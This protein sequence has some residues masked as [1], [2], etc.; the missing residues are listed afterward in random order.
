MGS[1]REFRTVSG[2]EGVGAPPG[3]DRRSGLSC[4]GTGGG[5]P[6]A[7]MNVCAEAKALRRGRSFRGAEDATVSEWKHGPSVLAVLWGRTAPSAHPLQHA[8]LSGVRAVHDPRWASCGPSR[9]G[10]IGT[11]PVRRWCRVHPRRRLLLRSRIR[12][13]FVAT[14]SWGVAHPLRAK[15]QQL[16]DGGTTYSDDTVVNLVT[17][18]L[19]SVSAEG[20]RVS[21][22]ESSVTY[23]QAKKISI[24][25]L[26]EAVGSQRPGDAYP[27]CAGMGQGEVARI[28]FGVRDPM[29][30][31][32]VPGSGR[33]RAR[34]ADPRGLGGSG[35]GRATVR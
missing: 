11:F 33:I 5:E 25:V 10:L 18:D 28:R 16:P 3:D 21:R 7:E 24:A 34:A 32:P 9:K 29:L 17:Y 35:E 19:R 12:S 6:G 23:A 26:V 13:L 27:R 15:E 31:K 1:G 14:Y 8:Q 30:A 20:I 4:S 2:C 22:Y